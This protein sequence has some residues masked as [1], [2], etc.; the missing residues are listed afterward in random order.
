[1]AIQDHGLN[2]NMVGPF[3]PSGITVET[4]GDPLAGGEKPRCFLTLHCSPQGPCSVEDTLFV[5]SG[6]VSQ[7]KHRQPAGIGRG[8]DPAIRRFRIGSKLKGF[9]CGR[10]GGPPLDAGHPG[11]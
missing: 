11:Q 4:G 5:L 7:V 10:L 2:T 9:L 6:N 3:L 8:C 1:V